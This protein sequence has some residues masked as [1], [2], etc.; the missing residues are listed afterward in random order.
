MSVIR[1]IIGVTTTAAPSRALPRGL[2]ALL[3]MSP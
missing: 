2:P 1:S 3:L